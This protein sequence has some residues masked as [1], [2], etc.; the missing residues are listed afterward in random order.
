MK[1]LISEQSRRLIVKDNNFDLL[2][3]YFAIVVA[4]IHYYIL[5]ID[6]KPWWITNVT[7]AVSGFF[8]LSGFLVFY[9]YS[10]KPQI[11]D[12]IERRSRRILPP[13]I[14]IVILCAL[15]CS[16]V[17]SYSIVDYFTSTHLYKY[18][19]ANLT[20]MN[21]LEPTLPGTFE[22]N[23]MPAVNGSLWT[24][25][26][27]VFLY[28]TVPF[29]YYFMKR[30]NKLT[31]LIIVYLLS[32]LYRMVF[33]YMRVTTGNE[34]YGILEGQFV[35]KLMYFYSGCAILLYFDKFQKY[36]KYLFPVAVILYIFTRDLPAYE[37]TS[38]VMFAIIVIG[39]AFNFRFLNKFSKLPNIS[40]SLYLFNF[41]I[42]QVLL[43]FKVHEY[44]LTLGLV[45]SLV[46]TFLLA[47]FSWKYIEEP[48]MRLNR[49]K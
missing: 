22:D 47:I 16:L 25:K 3:Y 39:I 33:D 29:V 28:C 21:F 24:M 46:L 49:K 37:Y 13:Y 34:I 14:F 42:V 17:S 2:R 12:F 41:P 4:V 23:L 7:E 19:A 31:V 9:S 35:G 20:F 15:G 40:Y 38:P 26:V 44:S 36:F 45:L 11:K 27:E 32:V 5:A 48:F 8:I 43:H 10:K 18:L 1:E 30:Y 6:F